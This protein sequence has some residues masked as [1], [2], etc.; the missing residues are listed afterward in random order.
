[1]PQNPYKVRKKRARRNKKLA[2]WFENQQKA[3]DGAQTESG[4]KDGASKK[5]QAKS[6]AD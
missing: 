1:M 4:Q 5:S 6:K 3:T 2:R